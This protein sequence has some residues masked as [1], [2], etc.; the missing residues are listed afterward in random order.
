[1]DFDWYFYLAKVHLR[2]SVKEFME[3]FPKEIDSL[4][5]LHVNFN[6]WNKDEKGNDTYEDRAYSPDEIPWL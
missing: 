5:K 4:W 6:G 2:Y 3:S 1:M